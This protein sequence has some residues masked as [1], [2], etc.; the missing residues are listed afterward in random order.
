LR[1]L[2]LLLVVVPLLVVDLNYSQVLEVQLLLAL[3][4]L[5]VPEQLVVKLLLSLWVVLLTLVPQVLGHRPA[6]GEGLDRLLYLP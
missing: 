4:L 5:L 1:N 2:H 3:F 6:N